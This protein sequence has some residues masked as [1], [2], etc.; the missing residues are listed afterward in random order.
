MYFK[1]EAGSSELL[2]TQTLG[3]IRTGNDCKKTVKKLLHSSY[4]AAWR[5]IN[6]FFGWK[7][8]KKTICSEMSC[9]IWHHRKH[10]LRFRIWNIKRSYFYSKSL[11]IRYIDLMLDRSLTC[12]LILDVKLNKKGFEFFNQ[13][14][15]TKV[16]LMFATNFIITVDFLAL[17]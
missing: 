17:H 11:F 6:K 14:S 4:L 9:F 5:N 2:K 1:N 7:T 8:K 10:A 16:I 13:L 12:E 15:I 3:N